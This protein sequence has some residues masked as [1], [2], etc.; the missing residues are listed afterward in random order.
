MVA[1]AL[2]SILVAIAVGGFARALHTQGEIS[3]LLSA[4][5]NVSLAIEEMTREIRTGN[6]FCPTG[7]GTFACSCSYINPDA[8]TETCQSLAFT[9]ADG[10]DVV[11][12]LAG[13]VSSKKAP[14]AAI[15][16]CRSRAVTSRYRISR[17]LFSEIS[18]MTTIGRRA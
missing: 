2:F 13:A 9:N 3:S 5:S 7:G 8:D 15:R 17:R 14:T 6:D 11:Y 1:I 10:Q 4:Q 12:K 16:F 18:S